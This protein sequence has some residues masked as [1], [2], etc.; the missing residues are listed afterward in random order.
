MSLA[1]EHA[2]MLCDTGETIHDVA[3]RLVKPKYPWLIDPRKSKVM[4][5]WDLITSVRTIAQH[6]HTACKMRLGSWQQPRARNRCH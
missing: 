6:C 3:R 5:Y 4:A 1:A 2:S